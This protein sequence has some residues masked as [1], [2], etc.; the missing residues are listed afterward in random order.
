MTNNLGR[1]ELAPGQ[2][3][4]QYATVNG[5]DARIDAAMTDALNVSISTAGSYTV[6]T[7][8]LT[9]HYAFDL[10]NAGSPPI[11]NFGVIFDQDFG[12]GAILVRNHTSFVASITA[13]GQTLPAVTIDPGRTVAIYINA[14]DAIAIGSGV[15]AFVDLTDVPQAYAG[16]AGYVVQVNAAA[17]GL[18]FRDPAQGVVPTASKWRVNV[19]ASND[20]SP[21]LS[22]GDVE[23][24]EFVGVAE[25]MMTVGGTPLASA[26]FFGGDPASL[27]FNGLTNVRYAY[28][29]TGGYGAGKY[30][31][32]DFTTARQVR[33]LCMKAPDA[34]FAEMAKD[35]TLDYWNGSAWVTV[36]TVTGETGWTTGQARTYNVNYFGGFQAH[37][38]DLDAFAALT[39]AA[40]K[41]P[42]FT[43]SNAMALTDFTSQ[44][45]S[46]LDDTTFPAMLTTLGAVALAGDTMTGP[47]A[48]SVGA[49]GAPGLTFAGDT[50]TGFWQ[51]SAQIHMSIDGVE[52]ARFCAN[53]ARFGDPATP[54]ANTYEFINPAN[55][56]TTFSIQSTGSGVTSFVCRSDS[57]MAF[58]FFRYSA[59]ATAPSV[60]GV[61][62]RGSFA[63]PTVP[64]TSDVLMQL[65]FSG[66]NGAS[67][68]VSSVQIRGVVTET[69]YSNS[70]RGGRLEILSC[71][72]LS[73]T[74]TEN[75]RFEH[76]TGFSMFG[77]NV[78]IDQNRNHRLRVYTVA[79]LP[80]HAAGLEVYCSDTGG[81]GTHLAS[82]G[83]NWQ[84]THPGQST[85][86]SDAAHTFST[87][88]LTTARF[89]RGN[90][91]LTAN[92]TT[93]LG[94]AGVPSGSWFEFRRD[95]GGAFNW[96]IGGLKTLTA[97]AQWARVA[98][99]GSAWYLSA[100]S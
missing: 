85:L 67:S 74:L 45:R 15:S 42:Y 43:G 26:P 87:V 46:V 90:S 25:T 69:T 58:T 6:S 39:S 34:F 24:R 47:L 82:D 17:T 56:N 68:A 98:Y 95:G 12:R 97:A 20:A 19:T 18:A 8:N 76:A 70:N 86:A 3:S 50:D 72:N 23:F 11:A 10:V 62:A 14:T 35:W 37:D 9:K 16:A 94:T 36:L 1:T 32:F 44:A 89:I 100:S 2:T 73:F 99:D 49:V 93:T 80:T 64:L 63:S 41:L 22:I 52:Y 54:A 79:T 53:S 84:R 5:S 40:N 51:T 29:M 92:R 60:S 31:E 57:T 38:A 55:T 61:K 81:G 33:Q 59:D 78:V 4:N 77:A 21:F 65:N 96:D 7:D 88:H 28:D 48:V 13:T 66:W 91:T 30:A 27:L 75:A 83:T 71:P